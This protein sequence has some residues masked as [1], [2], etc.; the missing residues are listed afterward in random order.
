MYK[1]SVRYEFFD[2]SNQKQIYTH[3]QVDLHF[4]RNSIPDVTR[5]AH[6][7]KHTVGVVEHGI[8]QGMVYQTI[9]AYKDGTC[10]VAGSGPGAEVPWWGGGKKDP[11]PAQD[12]VADARQHLGRALKHLNLGMSSL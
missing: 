3:L 7:L 5:A 11:G 6:A 9:I 2:A 12:G 10:R 4:E 1:K 8:F